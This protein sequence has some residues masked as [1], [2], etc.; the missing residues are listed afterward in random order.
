MLLL[1]QKDKLAKWNS[2]ENKSMDYIEPKKTYFEALLIDCITLISR[3]QGPN[4][5]CAAQMYQD[6]P[7]PEGY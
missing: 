2:A 4:V 3:G 6:G 7:C 1:V 5:L